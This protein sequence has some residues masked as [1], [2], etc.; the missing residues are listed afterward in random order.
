MTHAN[1]PLSV[2]GRRRLIE[3]CKTRPIAHVAAEVGIS[4]A[5]ASK[6][7]NRHR[8]HGELGLIDRSSTPHH[9]P[10]ATPVDVVTRIEEMR[11][12][13]KWSA[14]RIAHE[15]TVD[16]T[17]ISRRTVT[18]HPAV[19]GLKRRKFIGLNGKTN[20]E[21]QTI[22]ARRPGHMVQKYVKPVKRNPRVRQGTCPATR[23]APQGPVLLA[24]A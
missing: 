12:A 7:V 22:T 20:R 13:H 24:R 19:L 11:R 23:R 10:S 18:R 6:W 16:G 15:L 2:E 14:T 3:R 9:Q 1:A 5:T 21:P 4:R 8:R 17:V